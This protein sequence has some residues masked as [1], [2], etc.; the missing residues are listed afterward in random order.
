MIMKKTYEEPELII[1]FF[2]GTDV[3]VCSDPWGGG[4]GEIIDPDD[5]ITI[6]DD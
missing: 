1:K 2:P 5:P 6:P 3:I 4:G